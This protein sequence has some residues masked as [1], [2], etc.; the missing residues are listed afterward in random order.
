ASVRSAALASLRAAGAEAELSEFARAQFEAGY[1]WAVMAAAADLVRTADADPARAYAWVLER[2]DLPS[3]HHVLRASLLSVAA[4]FER[5]ET[6]GLL[7]DFALDPD[8]GSQPRVVAVRHLA[9]LGR[10]DSQVQRDVLS[11]LETRDYH[12]RGAVI[13]ALGAFRTERALHALEQRWRVEPDV[14]HRR[15]IERVLQDAARRG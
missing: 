7:R 10:Y 2:L 11:L 8:S 14:R 6:V 13:G 4:A 12:L 15:A 3:P 9:R 5:P 1:S